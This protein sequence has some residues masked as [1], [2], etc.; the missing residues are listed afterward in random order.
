MMTPIEIHE[1][2]LRWFPGYSVPIHSDHSDLAKTW[3]RKNLSRH[4]WSMT[5]WTNVYE[6]TFHFESDN[7]AIA[8]KEYCLVL[9]NRT[10]QR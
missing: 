10:L 5:T 9:I 4:Q 2:K 6:H 8:F 7:N 3:C 1:Y